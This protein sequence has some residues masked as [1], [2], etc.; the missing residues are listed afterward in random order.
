V[1]E[2]SPGSDG[3]G[4]QDG[5]RVPD[6]LEATLVLLRHGESTWVAEGRFQGQGDPPLSDIGDRQAALAAARLARPHAP[7]ALP[8]PDGPPLEI[9]HSPLLRAGETARL[10]AAAMVEPGAFARDVPV[11]AD[12]GLM[13]TGQGAWE[14]LTHAEITA[15]WPDVLA[16]WR[17][18]PLEAWAPG[19][20]SIPDVA[21]RLRPTVEGILG[22]LAGAGAMGSLDRPHVP[23]YR[24]PTATGPWTVVVG[25]DGVFKVMLLTLFDLPLARFWT[26]PFALAGLSVVEIRGGRPTLRAHNLTEH[27]APLLDERSQAVTEERERT[28]A[29]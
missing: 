22:R 16:T 7:P 6:G 17:R 19:G 15:R 8:V 27:L 3:L 14:G 24:E 1:S 23:G 29:L 13:E 21:A 5:L 11:R 26:F 25:H 10:V 12:R 9:V 20:E 28:G 4:V 2:P 18:R